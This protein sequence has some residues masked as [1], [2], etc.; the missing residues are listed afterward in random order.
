[1][2]LAAEKLANER[3]EKKVKVYIEAKEKSDFRKII[4][5]AIPGI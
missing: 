5:E 4:E 2:A 1:L 3:A